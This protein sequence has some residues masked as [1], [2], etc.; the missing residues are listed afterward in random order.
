MGGNAAVFLQIGF[1]DP[2]ESTAVIPCH[3]VDRGKDERARAV[4]EGGDV[5]AAP[6]GTFEMALT[7]S[8]R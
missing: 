7:L 4:A 3:R 8:R 2:F 1:C 6:S 5:A